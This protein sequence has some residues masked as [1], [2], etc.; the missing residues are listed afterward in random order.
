MGIPLLSL[1]SY[2]HMSVVGGP[3]PYITAAEQK[4]SSSTLRDR[5]TMRSHACQCDHTLSKKQLYY[6]SHSLY[7]E[8]FTRKISLWLQIKHSNL[9]FYCCVKWIETDRK[10]IQLHQTKRS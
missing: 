2:L 3:L 4:A 9:Y 1:L 6:V 7:S 10:N 8:D 5:R